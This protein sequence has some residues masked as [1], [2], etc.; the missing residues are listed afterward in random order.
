MKSVAGHS[1][2]FPNEWIVDAGGSGSK[3]K[4]WKEKAFTLIE[5]LHSI[6]AALGIPEKFASDYGLSFVSTE[7]KQVLEEKWIGG[8]W[9]W[10]LL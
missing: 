10:R 7:M 2:I 1:F 6:F 4:A 9:R 8:S 5:E 3:C